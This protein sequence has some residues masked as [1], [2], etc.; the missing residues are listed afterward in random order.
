MSNPDVPKKHGMTGKRNAAKPEA[1]RITAAPSILI[2]GCWH[3]GLYS[4]AARRRGMKL[5]EWCREALEEKL[6]RETGSEGISSAGQN[7]REQLSKA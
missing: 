7:E 4:K 1:E 3:R 2:R 6:E 5:A